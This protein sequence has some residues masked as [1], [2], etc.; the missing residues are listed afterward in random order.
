LVL[1][2]W[3]LLEI[4]NFSIL[5]GLFRLG[6]P[7]STTGSIMV[8]VDSESIICFLIL[9]ASWP[10]YSFHC[11]TNL[12]DYFRSGFLVSWDIPVI[13]AEKF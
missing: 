9:L 8:W 3:I 7:A 12:D 11:S 6:N 2:K 1:F 13:F 5:K 4:R 10:T